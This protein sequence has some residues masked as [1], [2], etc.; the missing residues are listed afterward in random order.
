M[1]YQVVERKQGVTGQ[2]QGKHGTDLRGHNP[3]QN[4]IRINFQD[5]TDQIRHDVI[6][7]GYLYSFIRRHFEKWVRVRGA[8]VLGKVDR[9]KSPEQTGR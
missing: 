6:D 4:L 1:Q 3:R 5:P 7:P 2:G 9:S 8:R